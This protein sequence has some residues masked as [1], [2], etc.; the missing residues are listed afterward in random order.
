MWERERLKVPGKRR[1]S[2]R[3]LEE[4]RSWA[5]VAGWPRLGRRTLRPWRLEEEA[6]DTDM[7]VAEAVARGAVVGMGKIMLMVALTAAVK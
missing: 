1:D 6:R 4:G 2:R 3:V 7:D 5:Q